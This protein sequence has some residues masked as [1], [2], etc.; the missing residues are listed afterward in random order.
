MKT[1]HTQ[2]P[3]YYNKH[4]KGYAIHNVHFGTYNVAI[5]VDRGGET[6]SNARLIA[7]APELLEAVTAMMHDIE[8]FYAKYR[9]PNSEYLKNL[10]AAIAKAT[11]KE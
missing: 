2:G 4:M 10:K 7:A 11:G 1:E 8:I 9:D 6:E 5:A 3:W